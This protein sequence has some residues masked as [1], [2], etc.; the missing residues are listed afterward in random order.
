ME[1]SLQVDKMEKCRAVYNVYVTRTAVLPGLKKMSM[2]NLII[3]V[4]VC[5]HMCVCVCVCVCMRTDLL[6]SV[7]QE[8]VPLLLLL[9][10]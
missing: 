10:H 2:S 4:C 3:T 5:V 1:I 9:L 8:N 7:S 6:Q